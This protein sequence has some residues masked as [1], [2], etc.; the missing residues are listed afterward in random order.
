MSQFF[1]KGIIPQELDVSSVKSSRYG[2]ARRNTQMLCFYENQASRT[3]SSHRNISP[4]S[5]S[6]SANSHEIN[7]IMAPS[8][9]EP[10][11]ICMEN[12]ISNYSVY[13]FNEL[14]SFVQPINILSITVAKDR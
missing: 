3:M 10:R 2:S 8:Q 11:P 14:F 6:S 4:L 5:S 1:I 7:S 9:V 12:T 13:I